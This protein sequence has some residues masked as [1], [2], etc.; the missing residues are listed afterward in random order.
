MSKTAAVSAYGRNFWAYDVSISFLAHEML[1]VGRE[2]APG[3]WFDQLAGS[4]TGVA[5]VAGTVG[6]DLEPVVKADAVESFA[7]IAYEAGARLRALGSVTQA[8]AEARRTEGH[9]VIW[10]IDDDPAM[11]TIPM[12]DLAQAMV[13]LLRGQLPKPPPGTWWFLGLPTGPRTMKVNG[14]Y[15][16]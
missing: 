8:D 7:A 14:S 2:R 1:A 12:A 5:I 6:L 15:D 11:S 9:P 4:L 16:G 13:D 3:P 10:R